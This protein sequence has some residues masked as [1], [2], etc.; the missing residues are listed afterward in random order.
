MENASKY[1]LSLFPYLYPEINVKTKSY[2]AIA[3]NFKYKVLGRVQ[4]L[5]NHI[6]KGVEREVWV[7][8]RYKMIITYSI[9]AIRQKHE[10]RINDFNGLGYYTWQKNRHNGTIQQHVTSHFNYGHI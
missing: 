9:C 2:L 3:C 5:R 1:T 7:G 6:K 8:G 4:F 10:V